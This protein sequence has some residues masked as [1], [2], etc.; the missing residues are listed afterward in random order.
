MITMI[1]TLNSCYIEGSNFT[2]NTTQLNLQH[3]MHQI[4]LSIYI[5]MIKM[6]LTKLTIRSLTFYSKNYNYQPLKTNAACNTNSIVELD[7]GVFGIMVIVVFLSI[8]YL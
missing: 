4:T 8:F 6:K 7:Y 2:Q 1:R 5:C 3:I